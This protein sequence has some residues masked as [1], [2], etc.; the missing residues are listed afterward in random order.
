MCVC[1][2]DRGG[3]SAEQG[4]RDFAEVSD[5]LSQSLQLSVESHGLQIESPDTTAQ[6]HSTLVTALA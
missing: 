2:F 6:E 1:V 3:G 5:G 4:R